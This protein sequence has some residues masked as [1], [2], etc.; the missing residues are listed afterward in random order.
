[1]NRDFLPK[2][3]PFLD[4]LAA[5]KPR[6]KRAALFSSSGWNGGAVTEL[7]GRITKAGLTVADSLEIFWAPS[8][9]ELEN[10]RQFGLR[11]ADRN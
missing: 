5:L 1:M 11:L 6:N 2:L 10:C 3:S 7:T 8:A 9:S 4:D